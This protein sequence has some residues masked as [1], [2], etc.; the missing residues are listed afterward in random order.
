MAG[1]APS[2]VFVGQKRR[3]FVGDLF[4][5]V[6]HEKLL[7]VIGGII[8][9]VLF[10]T[11]VFADLLAPYGFNEMTL[12][13]RLSPPG[14][15]HWL[16]GDHLGRDLLSRIIYG[17]RISMFVGL[18]VATLEAFI[19][20]AIGLT[21][22]FGGKLDIVMQRFVDA[23]MCFPP[24][25]IGMTFVA[26]LGPGLI[27]IIIVLGVFLGIRNSRIVRSAVIGVKQNVYF[28]AAKAI[29][30]GPMRILLRHVLVNIVPPIIVMFTITLGHAIL[31]ESTLSFLGFGIP[32]PAPSWGGMLSESGRRY[33]LLAPWMAVWP[34]VALSIVVYGANMLG[35][36]V[37]DV[38][39]PRLRG[40][41]GRYSGVA[42]KR[43]Q[44]AAKVGGVSVVRGA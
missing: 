37:R 38:V 29:G 13:L 22:F 21:G 23:W 5:R 40:G 34:G 42:K 20:I 7:G 32:P 11:G 10:F 4:Y 18:G 19:A 31:T 43:S 30:C 9:F 44:M 14:P 39:D 6:W 41:L 1:A 25:A 2:G 35:D 15:G 24:L 33:M 16:G 27:T 8:V 17:A 36:A 3:G 12:S 28:E 26:V